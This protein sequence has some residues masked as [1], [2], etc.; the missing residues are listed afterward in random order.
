MSH[1]N[2]TPT[3]DLYGQLQ[4]VATH[5]N[6][7]LFEGMLPPMV[8]TLQ[9]SG[10]ASGYFSAS[11]WIHSNGT[12]VSELALNPAVFATRPLIAL[13][14][15][16]AHELCHLWQHI[17]GS[18]SRPGY[19][20]SVWAEKMIDIGLM[21]SSTG[22]P[23]GAT[24]GQKMSD[25]PLP[26]GKFLNACE[27]LATEGFALTWLDQGHRMA[28]DFRYAVE[29][30]LDIEGDIAKQLLTPLG[31]F[32]PNLERQQPLVAVNQKLKIKYA[33][34]ECRVGVWGKRGLVINCGRCGLA[35]REVVPKAKLAR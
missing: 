6:Q 21:P 31:E 22:K 33:C 28:V 10:T 17:D 23:G 4:Q 30:P 11:R 34:P 3:A 1:V 2:V 7:A 5:F 27:A 14:Q 15:T 29:A 12:T 18:A 32:F 16:V 13:Y 19:H 25:Y 24:T 20:N 8:I 26:G 35:F 9:R